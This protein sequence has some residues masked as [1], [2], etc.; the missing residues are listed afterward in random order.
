MNGY[1]L[2]TALGGVDAALVAEAAGKP[3]VRKRITPHRIAAAACL[4]LVLGAALLHGTALRGEEVPLPRS[5]NAA[6]HFV[7]G[8]TKQTGTSSSALV[9]MTEDELREK[10]DLIL[11]GTVASVRNVQ[12]RIGTNTYHW[13]LAD[14]TVAQ[15]LRGELPAAEEKSITMLVWCPLETAEEWIE[16][17]DV[18]SRIRAGTEGI[19]ALQRYGAESTFKSGGGTLCLADL[20][21]CGFWDGMRFAFLQTEEGLVYAESAYPSLAGAGSLD[22]VARWFLDA[23]ED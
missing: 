6:A 15:I 9:A 2:L 17:T 20:A 18:I 7:R 8:G 1:E 3:R 19:F 5:T 23:A 13:A 21:P 12:V 14:V 22:D 16:D 11:R 4:L 10:P